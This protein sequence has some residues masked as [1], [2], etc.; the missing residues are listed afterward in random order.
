V[1]IT[2]NLIAG[3]FLSHAQRALERMA[4]AQERISSGRKFLRPSDD[5]GGVARALALHGDLRRTQAYQE[6]ASVAT[7]F[8]SLTESSL[9]E[10]SDHLA[11]AK[12]LVVQG[13]ND[14]IETEGADAIATELRA[15]LDAVVA[16]ANREVG[17]RSLFGGHATRERPYERIGGQVVYQ[18]D[19]GDILAELGPRLRIALNLPG[20]AVFESVPASLGGTLDLDPALSRITPLADL[21]GGAGVLG[22]HVRIT[23]SNGVVAD[24]DLMD[25]TSLGD[26]VD[27]I[28]NAGT[29][30]VASLGADGKTLVLQDTAGGASFGVEDLLGGNLAQSLGIATTSTTGTITSTDLDPAVSERTPMALLLGGG[31]LPPGTFTIRSRVDGE[32]RAATIDPSTANTLG[33]LLE[34]LEGARTAQGESLE[35]T[36]RL[37][38]PTLVIESRRTEARLTIADDAGGAAAAALGVAGSADPATVFQLLERAA[39]AVESRDH[40]AMDDM[41]RAFGAVVER[42]AGV[43]GAYGARARQA[44]QVAQNLADR[45]VDLTLRLSDVEDADLAKESVDLTRAQTVYNAS[46]STGTRLLDRTLF[47]YLG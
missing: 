27:G 28:N 31:G 17:D 37:D 13:M 6:N 42:T 25:A 16:L 35:I 32:T 1:R 43:R 7:A 4:A 44:L 23:D 8:M 2:E 47:D 34:L 14:P 10:L 36:A 45:T 18:G 19:R 30:V 41:I 24:V 11:H 20:P 46:L 9:Q 40:D 29:A 3:N 5:P 26:V 15:I 22:G 38:G 12:E 21:R 39:Q 33:D